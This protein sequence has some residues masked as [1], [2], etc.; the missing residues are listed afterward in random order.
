MNKKQNDFGCFA[1]W[2]D[3][4]PLLS[5][6]REHLCTNF[7]LL[8]DVPIEWSKEHYYENARRLYQQ[9]IPANVPYEKLWTSHSHKIGSGLFHFF[10]VKDPNPNY[11]FEAS[12]SGRVQLC[13]TNI[14]K[15]KT[16]YRSW[17]T[18]K[19]R[20]HSSNNISEF[21]EQTALILGPEKLCL[22]LDGN[23]ILS[24][25][26]IQ[27]DLEGAGGWRSFA[28]LFETLNLC[29]DY[30]ILRSDHELTDHT[31]PEDI[32]ILTSDYQRFASAANVK[33]FVPKRPYKGTV[34]VGCS[35]IPIDI[36]FIG[37]GYMDAVWQRVILDKTEKAG[38]WHVVDSENHFFSLV[39]HCIVHKQQIKHAHLRTLEALSSDLFESGYVTINDHEGMQQLLQLLRGYMIQQRYKVTIPVDRGVVVNKRVAQ[40]RNESR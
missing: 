38:L 5:S 28:H 17:F 9:E 37:D 21:F 11:R 27:R 35:T 14:T 10:V 6:I 23:P 4:L 12:V 22:I 31:P 33:Q 1:V 25:E 29:T 15:C 26:P 8:G 2:E 40:H 16:L 18:A 20:V 30:V 36:R 13:N 7:E 3:A 24:E 39:Y 34:V 32:D 19:Y